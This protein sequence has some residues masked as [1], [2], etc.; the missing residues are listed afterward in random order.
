MQYLRSKQSSSS[1]A[2]IQVDNIRFT[3]VDICDLKN[4]IRSVVHVDSAINTLGI[5]YFIF[6]NNHNH[7][8][9]FNTFEKV[10]PSV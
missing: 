8:N 1:V 5:L 2:N 10:Q 7:R 6:F 4:Q 3:D 9:A